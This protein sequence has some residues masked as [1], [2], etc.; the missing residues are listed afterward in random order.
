MTWLLGFEL[1]CCLFFYYEV[2]AGS[3]EHP[4]GLTGWSLLCFH[5]RDCNN[6]EGFV[7]SQWTCVSREL[8]MRITPQRGRWLWPWR[9]LKI[10]PVLAR[11]KTDGDEPDTMRQGWLLQGARWWFVQPMDR[12]ASG[13]D[14][15]VAS[16]ILVKRMWLKTHQP[17]YSNSPDHATSHHNWGICSVQNVKVHYWAGTS[18]C[19]I[20]LCIASAVRVRVKTYRSRQ[21]IAVSC[22]GTDCSPMFSL[23]TGMGISVFTRWFARELHH[24]S[25]ILA[26]QLLVFWLSRWF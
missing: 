16:A 19:W 3:R 4:N 21:W 10:H 15:N 25:A 22:P 1:L 26:F 7:F 11:L 18:A 17:M 20:A 24:E 23:G 13:V 6:A 2:S 12:R 14:K 8:R 5:L 9:V